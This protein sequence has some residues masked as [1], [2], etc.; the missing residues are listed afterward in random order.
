MSYSFCFGPS[1]SGKSHYLRKMIIERAGKSLSSL[2]KD[3]T[4]YI[5]IV[6]EQ[7]SMQTQHELI[8]EDPRHVLM[9]VDVLSFGRL[10]H[11]VFSETGEDRRAVLDDIG[12]SLLL[13]RA[14]SGCFSDL[15]I[16]RRGIHSPGMI[17]EIKSVLSEFMQYGIGD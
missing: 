3:R 1:G 14:A 5:V 4:K 13:R 2:G 8:D 16:L 15:Q 11:R 6:P 7:Y 9:N 10:A 17:D 12:K